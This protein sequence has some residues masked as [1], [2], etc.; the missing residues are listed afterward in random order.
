MEWLSPSLGSD[1]RRG[2][3]QVVLTSPW[4]ESFDAGIALLSFFV[5]IKKAQAIQLMKGAFSL[6]MVLVKMASKTKFGPLWKTGAMCWCSNHMLH[7]FGGSLQVGG[8]QGALPKPSWYSYVLYSGVLPCCDFTKYFPTMQTR[9]WKL[10]KTAQT[11]NVE[12]RFVA[13]SN[14]EWFNLSVPHWETMSTRVSPGQKPS[15]N[16]GFLVIFAETKKAEI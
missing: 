11:R 6:S 15:C 12:N 3:T 10:K 16:W 13:T 1:P 7:V 9:I 8:W 14:G 5:L 2:S 4:F